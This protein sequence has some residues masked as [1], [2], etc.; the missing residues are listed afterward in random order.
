LRLIKTKD[1]LSVDE[2]SGQI[3]SNE[4]YES[5]LKEERLDEIKHLMWRLKND[6]YG[7][8]T[9]EIKEIIKIRNSRVLRKTILKEYESFE[10]YST[11]NKD[12]FNNASWELS[13]SS[14]ACF[15][16]LL[17]FSNSKNTIQFDNHR[18]ISEDTDFIRLLKISKRKWSTVKK[19]LIDYGALR[20]IKFNKHIMYKINP[21]II[22][23][24]ME[25]D[26]MTYYAFRDVLC[27]L[28][29]PIKTLYWDKYLLESYGVDI[30]CT[31]SVGRRD[32]YSQYFNAEELKRRVGLG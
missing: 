11:H 2:K 32:F 22:G 10:N 1:L 21:A 20:K 6:P 8:S 18:N 15:C 14:L 5:L 28:F 17:K 13:D 23:H 12:L 27:N 16:R 26:V 4:E 31:S 29:E 7:L 19:E 3:I 30:F 25:I 9:T 24:S